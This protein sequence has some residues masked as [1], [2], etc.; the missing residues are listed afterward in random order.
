MP[1]LGL[2]NGGSRSNRLAYKFMSGIEGEDRFGSGP[3]RSSYFMLSST[4]L[5]SDFDALTGA[6]VFNNWNYKVCVVLK[7][8]VIDLECLAA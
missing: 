5:Q 4:E 8:W 2:S 6:G 3:I 1:T 7:P